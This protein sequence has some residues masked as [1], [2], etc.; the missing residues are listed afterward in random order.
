MSTTHGVIIYLI[1]F[2][3]TGKL[4][5][6][7]ALRRRFDC[8]LV[9]NHLI[10]NVVFSLIDPDG[11]TPLPSQVWD[12]VAEVRSAA[13]ATIRD[14]SRPGRSFV[15]TNELLQGKDRHERIFK[16]V[17]NVA[18]ARAAALLAVRLHVEPE[19]LARRVASP[20]RAMAFKEIDAENV[21]QRARRDELFKP[22]DSVW[23]DLDVTRLAPD[24]AA[25]CILRHVEAMG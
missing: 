23:V 1:G 7:K 24:D 18:K 10:N 20:E 8:L 11:K 2:A 9:D 19:E 12:R 5:I 13:L 21:L 17:E 16:D 4:T 14:L 25:L 22:A 6:A 3:G 15:F